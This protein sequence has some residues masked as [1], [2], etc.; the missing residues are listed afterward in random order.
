VVY[1]TRDYWAFGPCPSSGI[2]KKLDVSE[3]GRVSVSRSPTPS[4]EGGNR[5]SFRNVMIFRMPDDGRSPRI[6]YS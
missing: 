5:S 6:Q 3:T 2:L 1:R 4:H